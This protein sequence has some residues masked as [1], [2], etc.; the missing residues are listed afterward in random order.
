MVWSEWCGSPRL[1]PKNKGKKDEKISN[2]IKK[3]KLEVFKNP[4]HPL[5]TWLRKRGE[6]V[7]PLWF[8]CRVSPVDELIFILLF[9]PHPPPPPLS[10]SKC[11]WQWTTA[12]PERR[13]MHQQ[14]AMPVPAG[15]HW[16][17]M[18]EVEVRKG[19]GRMQPKL[20]P[21]ASVTRASLTADCSTRS[22][23][24]LH[25]LDS[26]WLMASH[27]G[28]FKGTCHMKN[29]TKP[30]RLLLKFKEEKREQK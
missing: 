11:M 23:G 7:F 30:K 27:W 4:P 3:F 15:L 14:R 1:Q 17:F 10:C 21:G 18:R 16:H 6:V 29:K 25:M 28:C 13:N 22:N 26:G 9:F 20:R 8:Q 5:F 2:K 12:L 19:P 24:T